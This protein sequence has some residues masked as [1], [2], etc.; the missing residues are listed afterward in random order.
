MINDDTNDDILHIYIYMYTDY[1]VSGA[2]AFSVPSSYGVFPLRHLYV[3][4]RAGRYLGVMG[5]PLR[6]RQ[7][8]L[9]TPNEILE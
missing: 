1:T 9:K 8:W 4:M 5:V 6:C 2:S 3:F 7:E